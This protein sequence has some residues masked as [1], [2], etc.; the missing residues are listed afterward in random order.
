ML[1]GVRDLVLSV[2]RNDK[3]QKKKKHWLKL[4][5]LIVSSLFGGST[6]TSCLSV[7]SLLGI[8]WGTTM[9]LSIA[10]PALTGARWE[11]VFRCPALS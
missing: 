3:Q 6:L 1:A 7:M 5:L 9:K 10:T 4:S 11:L 8:P 2:E